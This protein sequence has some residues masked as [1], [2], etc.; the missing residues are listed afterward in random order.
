MAKL[1]ASLCIVLLCSFGCRAQEVSFTPRYDA[2]GSEVKRFKRTPTP[3][4]D[5]VPAPQLYSLGRFNP[6][7]QQ[8]CR[9]LEEDGRRDRLFR[10]AKGGSD[11]EQDCPSCRALFRQIAQSCA[12]K[13]RVKKI[14]Q[15]TPVARATAGAR[16]EL[17]DSKGLNQGT[18]DLSVR[19]RYPRTDLLD[20]L[21]QLSTALYDFSPGKG[22]CFDAL[23]SLELRL[24][25]AP[26]LAVGEREYFSVVMTY[27]MAAWAGRPGSP[28][29][30][31]TP[32]PKEIAELFQ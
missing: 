31:A 2:I 22:P 19:P 9:L 24:S 25:T 4:V 11:D 30:N 32:N 18:G 16:Q 5:A 27:L 12:A 20:V 14:S 8:M 13:V 1:V 23:K 28:L 17:G 26:D 10:I 3:V 21:S 6:L 7:F 29:E 15:P